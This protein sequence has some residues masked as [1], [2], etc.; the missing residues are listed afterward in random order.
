LASSRKVFC[1]ESRA[2]DQDRLQQF[3]LSLNSRHASSHRFPPLWAQA[4]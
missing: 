4:V 3:R 2:S 1:L